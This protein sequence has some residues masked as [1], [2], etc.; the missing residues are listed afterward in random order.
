MLTTS[1]GRRPQNIK[2]EI[3][4]RRKFLGMKTTLIEGQP[5][6]VTFEYHSNPWL[7]LTQTQI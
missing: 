7:N 1:K 2:S 5:Q 3:T 4:F 6:N